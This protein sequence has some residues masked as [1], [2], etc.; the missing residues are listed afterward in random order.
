MYP[1]LFQSGSIKISSYGFMIAIAFFIAVIF[2]DR[3]A[4]LEGPIY[5][6]NILDLLIIVVITG[7][8]G[9]RLLYVINKPQE[10][11]SFL[12]IVKIWEGGLVFHGGLI[13][14]LI[15][16]SLF[17]YYKKMP[18]NKTAEILIPYLVLGQALGRIGCFLNG[19]CYG[20][21][22]NLP[23]AVKLESHYRHPTQ[24]YS[25]V[26]LF[27]LF[28]LFIE[29]RNK[30]LFNGKIIWLYLLSYS[31]I[32]FFLEFLRGDNPKLHYNFISLTFFQIVSLIILVIAGAKLIY[33]AVIKDRRQKTEVRSQTTENK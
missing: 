9:A 12:D 23:W 15:G 11:N 13:L 25:A 2:I 33:S 14:G 10:Y 29:I 31:V 1:I 20:T 8:I 28:I 5:R 16:G 27:L 26:T 32:R 3:K 21:F 24:I 6:N 22:S 19:C 18:F 17:I 30:K 7:I 4:V